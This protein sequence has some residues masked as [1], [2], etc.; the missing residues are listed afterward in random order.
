MQVVVESDRVAVQYGSILLDEDEP[1]KRDM[2]LDATDEYIY[3]MTDSKV[4]NRQYY[5]VLSCS[6]TEYSSVIMKL[7]IIDIITMTN[8]E[9]NFVSFTSC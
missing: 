6:F 7:A 9:N 1:I 5:F 8:M 2:A 4:N 3:A